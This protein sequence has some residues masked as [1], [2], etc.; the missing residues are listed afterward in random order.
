MNYQ[1]TLRWIAH[2]FALIAIAQ[3]VVFFRTD[4]FSQETNSDEAIPELSSVQT[5]LEN[6]ELGTCR[7]SLEPDSWLNGRDSNFRRSLKSNGITFTNKVTNFYIGNTRGGNEQQFSFA[8]HGDYLANLNIHEMGGPQGQFFQ[9]RVEHRFG[10]SITPA[11]GALLPPTLATDIPIR[12]SEQLYVTN[13]LFTQ[14]LSESFAIYAGKM[15]TLG[16]M[17][18]SLTSHGNRTLISEWSNDCS[19]RLGGYPTFG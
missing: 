19:R 4:C 15:D 13:F 16:G 11:S 17:N 3:S 1:C 14:A 5:R 12:D 10:E 18:G 8:G 2:Y 6:L 7:C 9:I